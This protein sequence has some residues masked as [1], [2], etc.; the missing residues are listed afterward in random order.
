MELITEIKDKEFPKDTSLL[1]SR[2]AARAILFD[3]HHQIPLLFVAQHHY[4]KL[5][6][7]GVETGEN[8]EQALA[9]ECLEEVGSTIEVK[10][11]VGSIIEWRSKYKLKQ[12]SYCYYG[13]IISKGK[14][15]FTEDEIE[16][17]FRIVWLS[18]ND[19]IA[20]ISKDTPKNYEGVFIQQRDLAFLKKAEKILRTKK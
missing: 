1:R 15:N 8:A 16:Q 11:D 3:E 5:P 14:P 7:G 17:G 10:G 12:I 2:E 9:R 4:H 6:G 19:A 18:L 13:N 20:T